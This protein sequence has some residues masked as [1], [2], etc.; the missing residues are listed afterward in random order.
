MGIRKEDEKAIEVESGRW[1]DA[2]RDAVDSIDLRLVLNLLD[3][4]SW[5]PEW[6]SDEKDYEEED[7]DC[8]DWRAIALRG[9]LIC[10]DQAKRI[11]IEEYGLDEAEFVDH[12]KVA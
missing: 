11:L 7:I 3:I 4:E 12:D 5:M 1:R 2:Y 10:A 8:L 9:I 6:L